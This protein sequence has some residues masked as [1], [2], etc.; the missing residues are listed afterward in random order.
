MT[1]SVARAE[2]M[3]KERMKGPDSP[4][5]DNLPTQVTVCGGG[6]G[7]HVCAGYFAWKGIRVSDGGGGPTLA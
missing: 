4:L 7:A 5:I 6:N 3:L 2:Q 1:L